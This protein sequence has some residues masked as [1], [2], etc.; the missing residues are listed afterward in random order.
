[1]AIAYTMP[2]GN[3]VKNSGLNGYEARRTLLS[4][5]T[6]AAGGTLFASGYYN[7]LYG[8][9]IRPTAWRGL[10]L[11]GSTLGSSLNLFSIG[12]KT[13][14]A[15]LSS[16]GGAGDAIRIINCSAGTTFSSLKNS[17]VAKT[18]GTFSYSSTGGNTMVGIKSAAQTLTLTFGILAQNDIYIDWNGGTTADG[19]AIG[20]IA[21]VTNAK[22]MY[23][24]N[25]R[26][27]FSGGSGTNETT[28]TLPTGVDDTARLANIRARC[29]T[30][31]GGLAGDYFPNSQYNSNTANT[32]VF[33][34]AVNENYYLVPNCLPSKMSFQG[35][36]IGALPEAFSTD[37]SGSWTLTNI[38]ASG[39]IV[40]QR[41]LATAISPIIDLGQIRKIT[42]LEAVGQ[43]AVR[44]GNEVN[45]IMTI[46]PQAKVY[47]DTLT[48]GKIYKVYNASITSNGSSTSTT[49]LIDDCFIAKSD[50]T[51]SLFF[52]SGSDTYGAVLNAGNVLTDLFLYEVQAGSSVTYKGVTY[53]AG[54]R[55]QAYVDTLVDPTSDV[56]SGSGTVKPFNGGFL[57][58]IYDYLGVAGITAGTAIRDKVNYIVVGGTSITYLG[59][60]YT[61]NQV[62]TCLASSSTSFTSVGG[63][64]LTEY[65]VGFVS[66]VELKTSKVD[67]TLGVLS[68]YK[69]SMYDSPT[70]NID[71]SGTVIAGNVDTGFIRAT[72][73]D[74]TAR[75][76]QARIL[77]QPLNIT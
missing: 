58:Q 30:V 44:N 40:D 28:Y 68:F 34:N 69:Y 54:D 74:L 66:S 53:N 52:F 41:L 17:I 32:N 4:G 36:Y 21:S 24:Q 72:A 8:G 35:K 25:C 59:T 50:T 64:T 11:D 63:S 61:P 75:Y 57:R 39:N 13:I 10:I 70:A 60:V 3:D 14:N 9:G 77:I 2:W 49:Y 46:L 26:F 38:D 45:Q 12:G 19:L 18:S 31:Y 51:Q 42:N 29:V 20:S 65:Y 7:A 22:F 55:F 15:S 16:S 73:Q 33:I 62:F 43:L 76:L 27:K 67:P 71:G 5:S 37:V 47:T 1:M 56:F 48:A 23:F 6:L